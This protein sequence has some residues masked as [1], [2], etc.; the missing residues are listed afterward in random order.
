MQAP[1]GNPPVIKVDFSGAIGPDLA[2]LTAA[3]L[4]LAATAALQAGTADLGVYCPYVV[5][6]GILGGWWRR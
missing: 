1:L 6:Y 4:T 3:A 2:D 5:R